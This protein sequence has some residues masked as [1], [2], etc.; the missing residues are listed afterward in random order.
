LTALAPLFRA[1]T[2]QEA[3]RFAVSN[4]WSVLKVNGHLKSTKKFEGRAAK[5]RIEHRTNQRSICLPF[6]E[7][8]NVGTMIYLFVVRL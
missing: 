1:E 7:C 6:F 3:V 4:K 5:R 2:K 8:C